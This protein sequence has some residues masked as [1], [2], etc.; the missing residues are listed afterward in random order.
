[1]ARRF[2]AGLSRLRF[3]FDP[4]SVHVRFVV[5]KV[6]LG[7]VFLRVLR[8]SPVSIILPIF[9]IHLHVALTERTNG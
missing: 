6:A 4:R 3:G 9:H 7:Q 5:D 8:Y 1:M 2:V